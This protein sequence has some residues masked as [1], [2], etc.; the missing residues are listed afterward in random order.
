M[1]GIPGKVINMKPTS[2][3]NELLMSFGQPDADSHYSPAAYHETTMEGPDQ[4]LVVVPLVRKCHVSLTCLPNTDSE[5]SVPS[6]SGEH[7]TPPSIPPELSQ[8][9]N[10]QVDQVRALLTYV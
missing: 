2:K 1:V 7:A 5:G 6:D 8:S 9:D 3:S 4:R 10:M